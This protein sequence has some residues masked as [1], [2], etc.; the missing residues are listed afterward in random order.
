MPADKTPATPEP[1]VTTP[2]ITPLAGTTTLDDKVQFEP[3]RLSYEAVDH[4]AQKIADKVGH[5]IDGK[6]V[7]IIEVSVLTDLSNLQAIQ[8]ELDLITAEYRGIAKAAKHLSTRRAKPE[9]ESDSMETA[10]EGEGDRLSYSITGKSVLTGLA[11][12]TGG[13][14]NLNTGIAA[15]S[16]L[17]TSAVGLL[18]L[19]RQDV[20]YKGADTSIDKLSLQLALGSHLVA[21]QP[22][23]K[24]F[25]ADLLNLPALR[26][27]PHCLHA[28][29]L[30]VEEARG[31]AWSLIAPHVTELANL[32]MQLD[33]A[34]RA[35]NQDRLDQ[36]TRQAAALRHDLQP[37]SDPLSRADQRLANLNA[38]LTHTDPASG[39]SFLAR[40]LN[41]E[42]LQAR[43]PLFL[44]CAA[45]ASGGS[46]RIIHSLWRTLFSGDG[47]TSIGGAVVRWGLLADDGALLAGGIKTARMESQEI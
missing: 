39:F 36:L 17:A 18:S 16:A 31:N 41:V 19:F 6:S 40:L 32:D 33:E 28:R 9:A 3:Q 25:I 29:L 5:R 10:V 21:H 37:I 13:L 34:A 2:A 35:N 15:A 14:A 42:A 38:T 23:A 45:A 22:T 7:V 20:Q 8:L 27:E 4:I 44:H 46:F 43:K 30:Q 12:T 1:T 47:I 24:V 26:T 11:K